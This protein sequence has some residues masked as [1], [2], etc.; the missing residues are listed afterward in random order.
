MGMRRAVSEK[1][2]EEEKNL[3]MIKS[4]KDK[5]ISEAYYNAY[6]NQKNNEG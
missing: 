6:R 5:N 1:K 2:S 4:S 3:K